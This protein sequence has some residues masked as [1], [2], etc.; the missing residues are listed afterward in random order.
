MAIFSAAA[1]VGTAGSIGFLGYVV[2]ELNWRWIG[3]IGLI[4][5]GA[6]LAA[7]LIILRETRGS[8]I[9][10]CVLL[11]SWQFRADVWTS[12]RAAKLRKETGDERYQC[13]ADAERKSLATLIKVG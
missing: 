13:R 10:S 11:P 7:I 9:L 4:C 6:T 1:F 3:W 12:R 8:V 5:S 2:Q